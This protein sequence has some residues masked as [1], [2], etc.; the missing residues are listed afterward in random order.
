MCSR[1][2]PLPSLPGSLRE[3]NELIHVKP[4]TVLQARLERD[5][6]LAQVE[7]RE[8]ALQMEHGGNEGEIRWVR[9]GNDEATLA[10]G[11]NL[12]ENRW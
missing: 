1:A 5:K 12:L 6:L 3:L 8:S 11:N 2:Q 10:E 4:R 7:R 9:I